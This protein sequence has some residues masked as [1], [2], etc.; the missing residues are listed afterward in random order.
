MARDSNGGN[1]AIDLRLGLAV[2]AAKVA[3]AG[4]RRT[5]RGGGTAAPGLVADCV[6]PGH[7][8]QGRRAARARR[9][10]RRR[11]ERQD[12]DLAHDR[13]HPGGGRV[14]A[15]STTGP[16]PIWSA[17]WRRPLPSRHPCSAC[18]RGDVGGHRDGR[19]GLRRHRRAGSAA[20]RPAQQPLPR[21]TRPLRRARHDRRPLAAALLAAARTTTVV[22]NA[23]DPTLAEITR[24]SGR[25]AR[26]P[27][28]WTS[29]GTC[30]LRLPHAADSAV[31]RRCGAD[32][33][34]TALYVSHLG[35]WRCPRCTAAR[36]GARCLRHANRT[37]RRRCRSR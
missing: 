22:V 1:G 30:W 19:G 34:Y 35:A 15:S 3:T 11:H 13:G 23:D 20:R 26:S 33:E 10:R 29:A 7:S 21:P 17:A 14:A 4:L 37:D 18:P 12:D 2:A 27:S 16:A 32:L 6:D 36:P 5:G 9:D 28:A 25:P 8:P 24:R 31:C